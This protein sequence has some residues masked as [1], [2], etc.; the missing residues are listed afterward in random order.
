MT[1]E[2][3][4]L[5]NEMTE[6]NVYFHSCSLITGVYKTSDP[7]VFLVVS[8]DLEEDLLLILTWDAHKHMEVSMH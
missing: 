8:K 3:R 6:M 7:D 4:Y 2:K 1:W 5:R